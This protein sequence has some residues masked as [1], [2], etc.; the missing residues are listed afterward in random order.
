MTDNN[1]FFPQFHPAWEA[2]RATLH[3]YAHASSAIARSAAVPHPKWWHVSLKVRPEGFCTDPTP[4]PSG[5][6]L[7]VVM[8][9]NNH[10][11][12]LRSSSGLVR[13][14]S[15]LEGMTATE[16]GDALTAAAAEADLDTPIERDRFVNDDARPYEP[17]AARTF[18][19]IA[20]NAAGVMRRQQLIVGDPTGPVQIWPHGFDMAFE[21]FG[22][23]D[24]DHVEDGK[25]VTQKAQVNFGLYPGGEPYFYCNPWPFEPET[26]VP[27]TLPAGASWHL[28]GW[29]GAILPYAAVAGAPSGSDRVAEFFTRVHELAAPTME[30]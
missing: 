9:L 23:K 13:P 10:V 19:E 14:F 3:A 28:E 29:Q 26:L 15:M 8:D 4:I 24:V 17:L 16:L 5:G 7:S 30:S 20:T 18:F 11:I 1:P 22:P 21:W 6:A 2:T 25:Q 12:T 27:N